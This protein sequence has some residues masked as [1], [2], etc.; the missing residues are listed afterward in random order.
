MNVL[1]SRDAAASLAVEA[2]PLPSPP[3][4]TALAGGS[5]GWLADADYVARVCL[6]RSDTLRDLSFWLDLASLAVEVDALVSSPD[7]HAPIARTALRLARR[8]ADELPRAQAA[9]SERGYLST[10]PPGVPLSS[11]NP[12]IRAAQAH[13][14]RLVTALVVRPDAQALA[15][16]LA[17]LTPLLNAYCLAAGLVQRQA[18]RVAPARLR[19]VPSEPA[20]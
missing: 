13:G 4:R 12:T 11:T 5:P 8:V 6:H 10:L 16:V 3:V 9:M 14:V 7:L 18:A 15:A 20:A 1:C 17:A 19:L 2:S